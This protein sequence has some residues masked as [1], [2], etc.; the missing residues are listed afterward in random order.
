MIS[1]QTRRAGLTTLTGIAALICFAAIAHA[2]RTPAAH[3]VAASPAA[4]ATSI[5]P[6]A[7][8]DTSV[9]SAD[10]VFTVGQV[11]VLDDAPTF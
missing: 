4:V 11:Q 9:P 1:F 10:S 6:D 8:R 2:G 3:G 5:A 7:D